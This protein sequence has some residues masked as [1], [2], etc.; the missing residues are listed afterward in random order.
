M[1]SLKTKCPGAAA[2]VQ[3]TNNNNHIQN[4]TKEEKVQELIKA[5]SKFREDGRNHNAPL[6]CENLTA[7]STDNEIQEIAKKAFEYALTTDEVKK[8][9]C[10]IT[11]EFQTFLISFLALSI[12]NYVEGLRETE[13]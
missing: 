4:T 11:S 5:T 3:S 6:F 12:S 9:N 13:Q 7:N 8:I 10:Q 2:T 1:I